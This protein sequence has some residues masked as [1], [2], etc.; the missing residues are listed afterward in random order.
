VRL[1]DFFCLLPPHLEQTK[2]AAP[3][4]RQ[5]F[6]QKLA[7][8]EA[9]NHSVR[10]DGSYLR[11]PYPGGD[12]PGD[13]G[14]CTDEIIRSYHA[15]RIDL[16]KEVHEDMLHNYAAYPNQR[17]WGLAHS[18]SNIDHRRV[19]NL[20]VFSRRKAE[21][22]PITTRGAGLFTG[23]LGHLRP[24][25]RVPH[26]GVVVNE[27]SSRGERLPD[28]PQHWRRPRMEDVLLHW[29]TTGHYRYFGPGL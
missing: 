18:D 12:V 8:T 4:S 28:R 13:T 6:L 11:I 2:P 16:Q 20:T 5:E 3:A 29:K 14:V 1:P 17:R 21:T 9:T 24:R 26:I 22:L 27:R 10:C 23:R 7:A 19:P 25:R 15:V